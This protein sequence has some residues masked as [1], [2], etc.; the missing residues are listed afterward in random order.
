LSKN[1][2]YNERESHQSESAMAGAQNKLCGLPTASAKLGSL[3]AI[4]LPVL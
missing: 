2:R 3:N 4:F 1:P